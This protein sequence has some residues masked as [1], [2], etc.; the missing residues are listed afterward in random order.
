MTTTLFGLLLVLLWV[1]STFKSSS[2]KV[3]LLIGA[4][5]F[6][7][8]AVVNLPALGGASVVGAA[9]IAA[10][11]VCERIAAFV[12]RAEWVV[13]YRRTFTNSLYIYTIGYF[14][15]SATIL[16]FVFGSDIL[17][18]SLDRSKTGIS[19][20]D[21]MLSTV[22]PL[23][24]GT[25][26]IVQLCYFLLSM[27]LFKYLTI[28]KTFFTP[29]IL[30]SGFVLA[31]T[32]NVLLGGLDLLELNSFLVHLRT[33]NYAIL[34]FHQINGIPR[35]IGGFPEASAFGSFSTI[36]AAYFCIYCRRSSGKKEYFL[37]LLNLVF[38]V[39]SFSSTAY[40][41]LFVLLLINTYQGSRQTFITGTEIQK[42]VGLLKCIVYF[43]CIPPLM[44]LALKVPEI[45]DLLDKLIF[46]KAESNSAFERGL[47]ATYG[48]K[49][50]MESYGLGVGIGSLRG[51]G[52]FSVYLGSVGLLG[53]FAL[54]LFYV[55]CMRNAV[56]LHFRAPY[57]IM[58]N[59][60]GMESGMAEKII[61]MTCGATLLVLF[62]MSVVSATSPNPGVLTIVLMAACWRYRKSLRLE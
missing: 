50:F 55:R 11:L 62:S 56:A 6:G 15:F 43:L 37:Y 21:R 45:A 51:N 20:D 34:D 31:G 60:E 38:A 5:P 12:L 32:I 16:P 44:Y 54:L 1:A 48:F 46:N 9:F 19:I 61:Y 47:W 3:K 17:V 4:I 41:G 26:N 40:L 59:G 8:A 35:V 57:K 27:F 18:F 53:T 28:T 29:Q 23:E 58:H 36:M 39:L 10:M 25:S 2:Y 30:H 33:A 24:F 14:I 52:W 22:V 7:S 49:A 13:Y 42:T